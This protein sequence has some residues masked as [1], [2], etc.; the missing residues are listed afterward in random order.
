MHVFKPKSLLTRLWPRLVQGAKKSRN[1][2][3][4]NKAIVEHKF[5]IGRTCPPVKQTA[6][7]SSSI[8]TLT[9]VNVDDPE[10][11]KNQATRRKIRRHVMKPIGQSRRKY[12]IRQCADTDAATALQ[13][14]PRPLPLPTPS[15]W[16]DVRICPNFKRLFRAM[17]MV[18]KGL[19]SIAVDDTMQTDRESLYKRFYN[20]QRGNE[21]DQVPTMYEV[22]QYTSSLGLVRKAMHATE[23]PASRHVITGTVICLAYFDVRDH[24]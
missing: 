15:Y 23:N 24:F 1:M 16:S 20:G 9:F 11:V 7:P 21:H 12:P 18:S 8:R 17:D 4:S 2:S 14:R 3:A 10:K 5:K 19:L 6:Y 22:E 13:H